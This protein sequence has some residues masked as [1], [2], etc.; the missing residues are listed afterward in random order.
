MSNL[1]KGVT[2]GAIVQGLVTIMLVGACIYLAILGQEIPP[3]LSE[4][5]M[6]VLGF[7][8]GSKVQSVVNG[9]KRY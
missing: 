1:W 8:F 7:Y 6:L 5:T 9:Y 2:E 3:L 4:G